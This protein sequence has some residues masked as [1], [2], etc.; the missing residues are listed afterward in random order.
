MVG[1]SG[2]PGRSLGHCGAGRHRGSVP[3]A[4][5]ED[6]GLAG[7][8]SFGSK[9]G[10]TFSTCLSCVRTTNED[11]TYVS[12]VAFSFRKTLDMFHV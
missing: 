7:V 3:A 4:G 6:G 5:G 1:G 12:L 9:I 10:Q 8:D 11:S 2:G